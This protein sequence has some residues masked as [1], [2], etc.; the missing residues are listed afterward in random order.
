MRKSL[1][2]KLILL[3]LTSTSCIFAAAFAYSHY[4]SR[5]AALRGVE[6]N[7]R[8]L[9]LATVNKIET[10]LRGVE[11]NPRY[12]A[13]FLE[14]RTLNEK[15]LLEHISALLRC[16][17]E[18]FGSAVAFEPHAFRSKSLYFSPYYCREGDELKLTYL[19][20]ETYHYFQWDWYLLPKE[21][22]RPIWSDPFYDEG[23]GNIIMCTYAAPFYR[24]GPGG[25]QFAGVVTADISLDWLVDIV[26]RVSLY[27]SGFAFLISHN[28]VFVTHPDKGL[29]MRESIFS[30]AEAAGDADLRQVGR[31]MIRG[32]EGFVPLKSHFMGK[33]AWMFYAPLPSIGWSMGILFPEEELFAGIR[34][35]NTRVLLIGGAGFAVLFLV[36][37]LISSN[38]TRPLRILAGRAG[39]IARGNLETSLP[40][41]RSGD[42]VGELS[43]SFENMR[44]A[45]K[46]YIQNLAATTAAKERI[47]SELKIAHTI[48][49][50][51]LPKRFPP[52]PEKGEFDIYA[53]LEPA[54]EVGG[55]LYD[56][57]L[58]GPDRLFLAVGDVSGKGVPAALFMAV[59]K[60]LL[61]GIAEQSPDVPTLLA[62]VNRELCRENESMMFV[63]LFCG[64]LDLTSGE[65][66]YSNAGHNPPLLLRPGAGPDW[67]PL[68]EGTPLGIQENAA[69]KTHSLLLRPGDILLAYT[70]GV[71]EAVGGRKGF[72]SEERLMREAEKERELP[73][74]ALVKK[75][76]QSVQEFAA[77]EAQYDDITLLALRFNGGGKT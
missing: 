34:R 26:S 76:V 35:L 31:D 32:G 60:T 40:P 55:D 66:V 58:L 64:V 72:Y 71:T 59:T 33:K 6:E 67:L 73:P 49:M 21:L 3:I 61:K 48:Q 19:G 45:L 9:A 43:R 24:K 8:N 56:F 65:F 41:L 18:I 70:D 75:V 23:G 12:L 36:V 20:G 22:N 16:N 1:A 53:T 47:E 54:K 14:D 13:S 7:A 11:K 69:Y 42:E 57:F 38:I 29:I 15:E 63:S 25:V 74:E 77:G 17:P 50:S 68:P 51:F 2:F 30:L 52:F 46:E 28:G 44:A 62:R 39:E 4:Y 27:K 10:V 37:V 5:G